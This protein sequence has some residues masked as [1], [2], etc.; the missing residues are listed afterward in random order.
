MSQTSI[1]GGSPLAVQQWSEAL[2]AMASKRPTP[3]NALTGAA[4]TIDKADKVLRKQTTTDMPIV[5]VR[6]LAQSAG[7]RVRVDC[8]NIIKLRAVMGDEN[9]EGKGA[10][11]DFSF[12]D[13]K[14]DMATLPVSAGGKMTQKRFQHDLRRLALAQLAGSVP[15]FL[16]QRSLVHMAGARGDQDGIEWVLPLA[17]DPDY[18]AMM[19]NPVMAPTYNRHYV[20]D[21]S[22]LI[23]G[24]QQLASVDTTDA[25]ILDHVDG[26]A[27]LVEESRIRLQP[28]K[29]PG[30]PAAG[31]DPILGVLMLDNLTWDRLIT[32]KTSGGNIRTWQAQAAERAK[33]GNMQMHPLFAGNPFLWRN[34]LVRKMGQ[35]A[36][37]F[38]G[39]G[40]VAHVSAANRYTAT[41]TNVTLPSLSGFQVSRS[42][43][44]GAQALAM[45]EGANTTSGVPYSMLENRTNF[46][47]NLEIAGEVICAEEKLRFSLPDG[48]GNK[49]P[50]DIG[51]IVIDS[52]TK[53]LSV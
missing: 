14:I 53:K 38:N 9:A 13:I 35:F 16:W 3:V 20:V 50:T 28:V 11:L 29:I 37:R 48:N 5:R 21:G 1:P 47:R 6:D 8:A 45:A 44:L 10:K 23:Q 31:D 39:G 19:V 25:M 7:D 12:Q 52:V 2:F 27:S 30:D 49:E 17:T 42:L 34:I 41:E 33:Y 24:G 22:D 15:S 18:A 36:V 46:E 32:D 51:V 4:P 43:F 40:N 26:L